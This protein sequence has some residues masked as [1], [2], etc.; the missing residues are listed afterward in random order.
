MMLDKAHEIKHHL[1]AWRRDFHEHP[2]LSFQEFRTA[3]RVAEIMQALG[4]RVR[5]GV[6]KT[7]VVAEIGEGGPVIAIR[8]D[9]DALP[10]YEQTGVSYASQNEGVMHACGHDSHTSMALGAATLLAQ[11]KFKGTVRFLF[12]PAEADDDDEGFSGAQR[13]IQDGAIDG[14]D[15]VIALHVDTHSPDMSSLA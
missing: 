7:G 10:I 1:V 3:A 11:E 6:G 15:A 13:M 14:V 12:Q 8:A 4:Y 2:E 5:T 9:M